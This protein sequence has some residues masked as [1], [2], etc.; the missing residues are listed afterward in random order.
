MQG[1]SFFF[2]FFYYRINN[3]AVH[4]FD[5]SCNKAIFV[6]ALKILFKQNQ[7]TISRLKNCGNDLF[8]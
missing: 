2:N 4:K 6:L 1:L 5:F 3:H 7:N 8:C